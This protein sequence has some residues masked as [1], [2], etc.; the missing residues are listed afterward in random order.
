VKAVD[1]WSAIGVLTP[2]FIA[3]VGG[4][5]GVV[6][7]LTDRQDRLAAK[8]KDDRPEV[9]QGQPV[10]VDEWTW[11]DELKACRQRADR[12][13]EESE[14]F[15]DELLRRGIEPR[16]VLLR[17]GLLKGVL[18]DREDRRDAGERHVSDPHRNYG[19]PPASSIYLSDGGTVEGTEDGDHR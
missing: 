17:A 10:V 4:A 1:G 16:D 2:L 18:V 13:D 9:L 15:R 3:T 6:K 12:I 5:V 8:T 7:W 19:I 14:A 11:Q